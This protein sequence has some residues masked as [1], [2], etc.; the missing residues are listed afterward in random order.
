MMKRSRTARLGAVCVCGAAVVMGA[1]RKATP[2][3]QETGAA[4]AAAQVGAAGEKYP[5]PRWPSYFKTP[6]S[7]DD[8]MPAARALVR[9]QSGLQG[10]GMGILAP[11]ESVLIVAAND[12]D[13]MVLDAIKK[14]LAERKVTPYIKFTYEMTGQ[15]KEEALADRKKR[16]K[17]QQIEERA[18]TRRHPGSRD[19]SPIPRS[20]RRG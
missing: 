4:S 20:R 17:G 7:A 13:P 16:T 19:S 6:K 1:C 12:A 8:L 15:S 3:G 10:K 5:A 14:A 11:G 9:N 2:S 18:S